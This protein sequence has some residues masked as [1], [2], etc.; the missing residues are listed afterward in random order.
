MRVSESP[1]DVRPVIDQIRE[2][3]VTELI[4]DPV[5][6]SIHVDESGFVKKGTES[7]GVASQYCGRLGKVENCQGGVFLG[8]AN[9]A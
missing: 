4:G 5:N 3:D 6:G 7:V 8:Y 2:R 9:G 1:W